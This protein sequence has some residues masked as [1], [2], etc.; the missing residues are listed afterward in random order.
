MAG[1]NSIGFQSDNVRWMA[2]R[3]FVL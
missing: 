3:C 1:K 2:G